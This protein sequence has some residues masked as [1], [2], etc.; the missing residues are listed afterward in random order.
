MSKSLKKLDE[1]RERPGDGWTMESILAIAKEFG[2]SVRAPK[3]GT[4]YTLSHPDSPDILC[5]RYTMPVKAI[6]VIRFV[7]MIDSITTEEEEG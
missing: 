3:W 1:M 7:S 2:V 6:Y 5:F 4:F